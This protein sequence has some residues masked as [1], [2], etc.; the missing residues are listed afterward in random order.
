MGYFFLCGG[1]PE[2]VVIMFGGAV[3][4]RAGYACIEH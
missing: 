4:D 1:R 3:F 2:E